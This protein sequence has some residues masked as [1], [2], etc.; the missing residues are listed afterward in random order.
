MI[1]IERRASID[2][3]A[4]LCGQS[5][6]K[7]APLH[8]IFCVDFHRLKRWARMESA[9]F[10]ADR[11]LRPFW[12]AFQ[13]TVLCAQN[14]CTAADAHGLGSVYIG[15][16][17]DRIPEIRKMC[18]LPAGVVPVVSLVVGYPS[19]QPAPRKRLGAKIV[20]HN[21]VYRKIT[22]RELLAGF[23]EKYKGVRR[24]ITKKDLET[25]YRVCRSVHGEAYA[26]RSV[27]AAEKL[28]YIN[29]A[30]VYFGLNYQA[31]RMLSNT[32]KQLKMLSRAG[33][34]CFGPDTKTT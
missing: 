16:I 3:L 5:F 30:Q 31:D 11:S 15:P 2:R 29:R 20:V 26:K 28:G 1:K 27:K 21:E 12:I 19:V 24:E 8:F 33:L 32:P 14:L 25:L 9:P 18:R 22:D 23:S 13:D 7:K 4:E 10:S 34:S 17:F 6:M